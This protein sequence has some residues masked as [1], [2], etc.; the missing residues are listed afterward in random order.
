[1]QGSLEGPSTGPQLVEGRFDDIDEMAASPL[2]WNQEYEQ[3]GR[4]RFNGHMAQG[5]TCHARPVA[6]VSKAE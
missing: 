6:F 3:I 1:M 2:A 5:R 4:G